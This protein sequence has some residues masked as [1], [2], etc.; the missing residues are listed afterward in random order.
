MNF[1]NVVTNSL[2]QLL[3]TFQSAIAPLLEIGKI[4]DW[5]GTELKKRE[6]KIR[7]LVIILAGKC[8]VILLE[9]LSLCSEAQEK[10]VEQTKGWWRKRTGKNGTREWNILTMGN[11]EVKLKLPYV[12]ERLAKPRKIK[13]PPL[14]GF[15]P[16]L[17]WLGL[18]KRVTPLVWSKIAEYGTMSHSF[19]TARLTLKDWGINVNIRRIQS[20]TYS[21]CKA[22]LSQRRSKV[23]HL[24]QGD[25]E[26]SN[27]LKDKRVVISADGGRTRLV[28]YK[29]RKR[30]KKTN[31]RPYKGEWREPKLLTIYAVDDQ[32]R[33]IKTGEVPITNDG[34]FGDSKE[35]LVI[36]EMYLVEL[37]INQAK[38]ILFIADGSDWMWKDIPPLLE[39]LGCEPS[40]TYY[41][42]D[43]YHV[44]E[45]LSRFAQATF[46]QD[47]ERKAW[48]K[49]ARSKLRKGQSEQ[50][51]KEMIAFKKD[52]KLDLSALDSEIKHLV[53]L[54]ENDRI[55]YPLIAEKK[56]PIGSGAI[57]SLIRQ[58]VN[59]RLKGNGK[60]WRQYNAEAILHA[61]CQWLAGR[62]S[63]LVDSILTA[64]IYP[65]IE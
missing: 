23:F 60:F 39:R 52:N 1:Q 38:E 63:E 3:K 4:E 11:V 33:K 51:I 16:F 12:V 42:Q 56:L 62:W 34:T 24:K 30:N 61:R 27:I 41:L 50:L 55:N 46:N 14:Q 8:I 19:E 26:E 43:F 64:R 37:G 31:R 58:A 57:E 22:A 18:E 20:L 28:E 2:T 54:Q 53:K 45:H 47:N 6:E 21:L 59:L 49:Q 44:T 29:S 40:K 32:G 48:F 13:K 25:L 10:A 5:D 9:K 36:L 17:R 65:A 15:C 7:E 35:F